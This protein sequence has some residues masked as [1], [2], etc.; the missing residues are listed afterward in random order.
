MSKKKQCYLCHKNYDL[1]HFEP[2]LD[3]YGKI[4]LFCKL[5][6]EKHK[7]TNGR[8]PADR[9]LVNKKP[10]NKE[11]VNLKYKDNILKHRFNITIEDFNLMLEKQNNCCMICGINQDSLQRFLSVDHDHKTGK[12]RDLLCNNC[13]AGLGLFNDSIEILKNALIYLKN[14]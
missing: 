10:L 3:K 5:N 9:S 14:Q 8:K 11:T 4:R 12:V 1:S 2:I 6:L 13:N 7:D